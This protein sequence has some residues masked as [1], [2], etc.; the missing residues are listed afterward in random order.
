MDKERFLSWRVNT[1]N[2]ALGFVLK[3]WEKDGQTKESF[4]TMIQALHE[5]LEATKKKN[6]ELNMELHQSQR[7]NRQL[8]QEKAILQDNISQEEKRP[9]RVL[10]DYK[11]KVR[12]L[13][14][15]HRKSLAD[16]KKQQDVLK[17]QQADSDERLTLQKEEA[18]RAL[19]EQAEKY[20]RELLKNKE[21][22][23]Q[24]QRLVENLQG[25]LRELESKLKNKDQ[26]IR[27]LENK[28]DQ[29][30]RM[31]ELKETV[32]R[33]VIAQREREIMFLINEKRRC[34]EELEHFKLQTDMSVQLVLDLRCTIKG[35]EDEKMQEQSKLQETAEEL[36]K[37]RQTNSN[38]TEMMTQLSDANEHEISKLRVNVEILETYVRNVQED[39]QRCM[40]DIEDP[41]KLK[42][43][44]MILKRRYIDHDEQ[45]ETNENDPVAFQHQINWPKKN[46]GYFEQINQK[47]HQHFNKTRRFLIKL[48]NEKI[49]EV[50]QLRTEHHRA[51]K[52]KSVK[53]WVVKKMFKIVPHIA[54]IP[55][56]LYSED[57]QPFGCPEY[58]CNH[59]G[60]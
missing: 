19:K 3:H 5:E 24:N 21:Q 59:V 46:F 30:M 35:L 12:D 47:A 29:S 33:K 8:V 2:E 52:P 22:L 57:W 31:S 42:S 16:C 39:I 40:S 48:L 58:L 60:Q 49:M 6:E 27:D 55:V 25:Q 10:A 4:E 26:I 20:G 45:P 17:H 18:D 34:E 44:V 7:D 51:T 9:K 56:S 50:E 11:W 32:M 15:S 13:E 37:A 54:P 36:S 28:E 53:S 14:E 38:L 23:N 43:R 1:L 41:M